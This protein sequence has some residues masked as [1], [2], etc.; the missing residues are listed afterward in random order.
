MAFRAAKVRKKS[1]IDEKTVCRGFD[2]FLKK[3]LVVFLFI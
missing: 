1:D 3:M 2:V